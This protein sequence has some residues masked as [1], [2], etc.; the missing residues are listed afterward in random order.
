MQNGG[1]VDQAG[2]M[3]MGLDGATWAI[4]ELIL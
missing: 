1:L 4:S 3:L 2:A